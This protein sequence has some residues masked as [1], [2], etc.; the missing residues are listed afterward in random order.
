MGA[1]CSQA[2]PE[3]LDLDIAD[4]NSIPKQFSSAIRR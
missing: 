4:Y 1:D 2:N 3:D